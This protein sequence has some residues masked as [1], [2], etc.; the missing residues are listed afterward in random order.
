MFDAH[1]IPAASCNID[2][3]KNEKLWF[4][5]AFEIA[6]WACSEWEDSDGWWVIWNHS[7]SMEGIS[8]FGFSSA[9]DPCQ[10]EGIDKGLYDICVEWCYV[11]VALLFVQ[12]WALVFFQSHQRNQ[13]INS[14]QQILSVFVRESN[15]LQ[16]QSKIFSYTIYTSTDQ[17]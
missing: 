17:I 6:S 13:F 5:C 11:M 7:W 4:S 9:S 3:S 8:L 12:S 10:T 14:W 2:I 16:Y 1:H 15:L